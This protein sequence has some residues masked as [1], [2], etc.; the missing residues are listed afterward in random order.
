[1]KIA[2]TFACIKVKIGNKT[3]ATGSAGKNGVILFE[4]QTKVIFNQEC[5]KSADL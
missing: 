3:K 5:G 1:M 2:E 4:H